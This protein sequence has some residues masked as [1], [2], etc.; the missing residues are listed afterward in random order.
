[1]YEDRLLEHCTIAIENI[2]DLN[3]EGFAMARRNGVGASD[4]SAILGTMPKFRTADDVLCNKLEKT[5]TDA[6]KAIGEIV[7]VRKGKT[8]EPYILQQAE[9]Q[10]GM[11]IW[12]S[13]NMYRLIDYPHLT[14]NYDGLTVL[15]DQLIPVEA[16]F[17]STYGDKYYNFASPDPAPIGFSAGTTNLEKVEEAAK[18][19]GIPPYYLVQVQQQLMGTGA[20]YA[21]LAALRDKDWT[22]YLF[23]IPA[24]DW[25]QTWLAVETYRF[26]NRVERARRNGA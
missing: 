10:L 26:W 22:V 3:E 8:L 19:H 9:K 16:K 7:N 15:D 18:W 2:G 4:S 13:A 24:Y 14:I 5:Y 12:K 6:E 23:K 11:P 25:M 1:M 21:Y 17:V 20:P